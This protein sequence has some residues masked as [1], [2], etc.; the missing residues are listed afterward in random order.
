MVGG[1]DSQPRQ[2]WK[3]R[4]AVGKSWLCPD[5]G[6]IQPLPEDL[7][8]FGCLGF[9]RLLRLDSH[10]LTER[11]HERSRQVHPDFFQT[12]SE[13]EQAFS[14]DRSAALNR[15]YRT[16]RDP[17]GRMAYL[18]RLESGEAE[19]AAKAPPDLLEEIF[20][21]Q[22]S[23]E[24]FQGFDPSQPEDEEQKAARQQLVNERSQLEH[25]LARLDGELEKLAEQ[26]DG[27][28]GD[29]ASTRRGVVL[30]DANAALI[31]GMRE[32][33]ATRKYLTNT[34][35]DISLTL[36]GRADAKDHRH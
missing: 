32:R 21:L 9:S 26:W 29:A 27:L 25:R 36:E 28:I 15:A 4:G 33:L 14:L 2:C 35:N 1:H 11:F 10:I 34:M 5:C 6:V 3:C 24:T 8:H 23:L 18:V 12:K 13:R 30:P 19:I 22:E 31:A 20:E 17:V 16:L 7:D